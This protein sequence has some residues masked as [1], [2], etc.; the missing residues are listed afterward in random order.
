MQP[1]DLNLSFSAAASSGAQ[2]GD[3]LGSFGDHIFGGGKNDA[4][5]ST[6]WIVAAVVILFLFL[7]K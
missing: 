2:G 4:Q 7:R 3:V 6:L 5:T 1:L